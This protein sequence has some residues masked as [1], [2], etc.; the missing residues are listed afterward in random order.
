MDLTAYGLSQKRLTVEKVNS[1]NILNMAYT[2]GI[3][4]F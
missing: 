2:K 3:L 1:E 4:T